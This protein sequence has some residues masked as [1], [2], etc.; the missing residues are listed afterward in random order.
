MYQHRLPL[1]IAGSV[2]VFKTMC[3]TFSSFT[4]RVLRSKYCVRFFV[5]YF[6]VSFASTLY[7]H[8]VGP[9]RRVRRAVDPITVSS[10]ERPED[11]R[12][13]SDVP[14]A[15]SLIRSP[16]VGGNEN[17]ANSRVSYGHTCWP[18]GK[19]VS[20]GRSSSSS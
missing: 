15:V 11:M 19:R 14:T 18:V 17:P 8:S 9:P 2:I 10:S 13:R 6:R 7:T 3:A 16:G 12:G 20:A 1:A 5:V 4:A